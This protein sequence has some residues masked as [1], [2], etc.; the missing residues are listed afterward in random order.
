MP[1]SYSTDAINLKQQQT[2]LNTELSL[3]KR[4][5]FLLSIEDDEVTLQPYE[6]NNSTSSATQLVLVCQSANI[7]LIAS[8]CR[9]LHL[10]KIIV[11]A[12]PMHLSHGQ[13]V[14]LL[15]L[16]NASFDSV[17][18]NKISETFNVDIFPQSS[19]S[20]SDAGVLIMDMDSTVI[21]MECIDEIAAL[22]GV[23][24]E[25][26][27]VTERAM[28]GEIAF[29]DSLYHRVACLKGVSVSDLES[30]RV[31]L[32]FSPKFMH[33]MRTLKQHGWTLVLASGGFTFFADYIKDLAQLDYA[34]SNVLGEKNGCLTGTVEGGVV[35]AERKAQILL[36]VANQQGISLHKTIAIGD[37]A[38]DL[39]MLNTAG[40]S[41]AYKAKPAVKVE[42]D[43]A[44]NTSDFDSLL[45][46]LR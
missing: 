16:F 4:L 19:I 27:D 22:A 38:N 30:I 6:D 34:Y 43:A 8:V 2:L 31:R 41:I 1:S 10:S 46:M 35:D 28:R 40:W 29:S 5:P 23:K 25:V 24:Q 39:K 13:Y 18:L 3:T 15:D 44:I 36:E 14:Y 11:K 17:L 9:T 26:S 7:N 45:Y 20:L 12:H 33:T 21:A 37:G 32:P 42:A